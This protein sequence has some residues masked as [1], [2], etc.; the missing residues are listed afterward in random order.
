[1][2]D[3]TNY[4]QHSQRPENTGSENSNLFL[5]LVYFIT[6]TLC[7][8]ESTQ[9]DPLMS[10]A[11]ISNNVQQAGASSATNDNRDRTTPPSTP[12]RRLSTEGNRTPPRLPSPIHSTKLEAL[13]RE[14]RRHH[15]NMSSPAPSNASSRTTS[16]GREDQIKEQFEDL[17][18]I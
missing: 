5:K 18:Y 14:G 12:P 3:E 4:I 7:G 17:S 11:T 10:D 15:T 16:P 1:M 9:N 8:K 6:C 2:H 13:E